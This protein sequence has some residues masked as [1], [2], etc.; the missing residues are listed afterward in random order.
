MSTVNQEALAQAAGLRE[1]ALSAGGALTVRLNQAAAL[2][3]QLA[4]AEPEQPDV[5]LAER[6]MTLRERVLMGVMSTVDVCAQA[7]DRDEN[8]SLALT[9]ER[10][11][12]ELDDIA[13]EMDNLTAEVAEKE[14]ESYNAVLARHAGG[15]A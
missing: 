14:G 12:A 3:E 5:S 15:A 6:L 11:Y 1:A 9:L 2:L 4:P 13:G 7:I 10:A 8:I